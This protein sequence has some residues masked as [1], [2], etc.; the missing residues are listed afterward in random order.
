MKIRPEIIEIEM[1]KGG[2][3]INKMKNWS[4]ENINN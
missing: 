1:E 4:F 3:R 2:K